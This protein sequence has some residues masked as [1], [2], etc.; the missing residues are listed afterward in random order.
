MATAYTVVP[1][2]VQNAFSELLDNTVAC[3]GVTM[4]GLPYSAPRQSCSQ[5]RRTRAP[6]SRKHGKPA[7]AVPMSAY[8][9]TL[10]HPASIAV[11]ASKELAIENR[12]LQ[13]VHSDGDA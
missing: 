3:C 8:H 2:G 5:N 1:R 12:T 4:Q 9:V 7:A 6:D 11:Q 10:S 13:M